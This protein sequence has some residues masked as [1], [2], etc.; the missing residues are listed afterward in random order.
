M[1]LNYELSK[2]IR[3]KANDKWQENYLIIGS[4]KDNIEFNKLNNSFNLIYK[5]DLN[6]KELFNQD[7]TYGYACGRGGIDPKEKTQIDVFF[8]HNDKDSLIKWLQST[9]TEKQIYA[10]EG[11]FNL[12]KK[13]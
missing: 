9:N 13:E 2:D 12:N 1:I 5:A 3:K 10:I 4:Y 7:I 6:E 11:L 8:E